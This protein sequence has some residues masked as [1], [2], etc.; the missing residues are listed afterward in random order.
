MKKILIHFYE[1]EYST[2]FNNINSLSIELNNLLTAFYKLELEAKD[3]I[4]LEEL[5]YNPNY[6]NVLLSQ[7]KNVSELNFKNINELYKFFVDSNLFIEFSTLRNSVAAMFR[8]RHIPVSYFLIENDIIKIDNKAV[9]ALK[10]QFEV[11]AETDAE[12]SAYNQL[13][14][15]CDAV[16]KVQG[17]LET[18]SGN[19][20]ITN[21][22]LNNQILRCDN[23]TLTPTV[24]GV[25][26]MSKSICLH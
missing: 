11:Y 25:K 6:I 26:M 5:L 18:T 4:I 14:A 2:K 8:K 24:N 16:N 21:R 15:V 22:G 10:K 19:R 13:K 9:K 1:S 3:G 17:N 12:I 7:R 23:G 20:I